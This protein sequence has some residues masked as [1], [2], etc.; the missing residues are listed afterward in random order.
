M[1]DFLVGGGGGGT[2]LDGLIATVEELNILHG[3]TA[4]TEEINAAASAASVGVRK[5]AK[6]ALPIVADTDPHTTGITLPSGTIL[7]DMWVEV[8]KAETVGTEKYV[9]LYN[10]NIASME[11][12]YIWADVS[13]TGIKIPIA[14]ASAAIDGQYEDLF[15]YWIT[16]GDVDYAFKKGGIYCATDTTIYYAFDSADFET[17][18]AYVIVEYIEFS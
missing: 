8:T 10:A 15:V 5:Y 16:V 11:A 17:L 2:N 14:A 9:N 3:V 18:V 1:P 12:K 6:A 4:T 7:T 13:S